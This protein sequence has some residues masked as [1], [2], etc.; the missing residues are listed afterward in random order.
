MDSVVVNGHT[1][2]VG[3]FEY[4][5]ELSQN[6]RS[7]SKAIPDDQSAIAWRKLYCFAA[8]HYLLPIASNRSQSGRKK[9]RRVEIFVYRK[10][11]REMKN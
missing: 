9:N 2:S 1:D 11:S 4:N 6:A 5:R 10:E 8:M 7:C 3:N